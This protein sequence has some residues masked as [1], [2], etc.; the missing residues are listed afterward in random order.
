MS[1]KIIKTRLNFWIN[2]EKIEEWVSSKKI[3][4]I[5]SIGRSGTK[6]LADLLNKAQG[7]YIVHEPVRDDFQAY[8]D[9]FHS[10]E[11]ARDYSRHF[12]KKEIY[13]RARK[14]GIKSYGE[15]NSLLRR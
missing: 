5:L 11:K 3:F 12:R 14:K 15:V 13:L 10:E 4:F 7:V 1:K 6:F 8:Q 2:S 9:A